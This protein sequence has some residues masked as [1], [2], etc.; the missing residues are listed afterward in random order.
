VAEAT[1]LQP[2]E[3]VGRES[4]VDGTLPRTAHWRG[5]STW[6]PSAESAPRLLGLA[7]AER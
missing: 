6:Y 7:L 1:A 4:F 3:G 5:G 2:S